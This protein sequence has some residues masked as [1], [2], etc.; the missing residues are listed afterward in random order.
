MFNEFLPA[1][2]G[3]EALAPSR[4]LGGYDASVHPSVSN[5]VATAVLRAFGHLHVPDAIARQLPNG[6]AAAALALR[7]SYFA[8][9]P[10]VVERGGVDAVLRALACG[11]REGDAGE[12][13]GTGRGQDGDR[14]DT[15]TRC[16]DG[17]SYPAFVSSVC[18]QREVS[19][20]QISRERDS[21]MCR[22]NV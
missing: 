16:A 13:E 5:A 12:Q 21:Q 9:A 22:H 2:L 4:D 10:K 18:V 8:A 19:A 14:R 6:T 15:K 1:L 3:S 20:M 7:E 17:S 11:T